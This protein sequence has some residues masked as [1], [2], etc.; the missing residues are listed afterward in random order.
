MSTRVARY[1]QLTNTRYLLGAAGWLDFLNQQLDPGHHRF[2]VIEQFEMTPKPGVLQP[3]D[4]S[5]LAAVPAT[6]GPFALYEFAGAL[7]RA[8]LYTN[9]QV[10]TNNQE[11]LNQLTAPEFDPE[12]TVLVNDVIPAS[13]TSGSTNT[14][15]GTVEFAGYAPTDL[16][17]KATAS[18]PSVLLLNDRYE[19]NWHAFVDD[20]PAPLLRCNY[21]MRGLYLTPGAHTIEFR[22]QPPENMFY[23]SLSA[24]IL[25]VA[26]CGVLLV[27]N[28]SP[29]PKPAGKPV[30]EPS[31]T[32]KKESLKSEKSMAAR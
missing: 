27:R 9:W 14:V 13:A 12:K 26:L 1:W 3:V 2:R 16:K 28:K 5:Q 20:T 18:A 22:F 25:G 24:I 17:L 10:N 29:G 21:L 32:E 6:N 19:P 30:T 15:A 31:T 7:P 8:K 23:V 4:F 11:I